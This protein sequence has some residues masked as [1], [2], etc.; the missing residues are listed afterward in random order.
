VRQQNILR[1]LGYHSKFI[2]DFLHDESFLDQVSKIAGERLCPSTFGSHI[3]QV[4]F[5]KVGNDK[6]EV[7]KWH[8]DSV[9][10]VLVIILSDIE[11]MVGGELEVF[12]KNLGGKE[13]TKK[14][15][16]EGLPQEYIEA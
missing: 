4:N 13:A 12:R 2:E 9:D 1:G 5:G 3:V 16:E 14:L 8:F 6:A 7:D 10:Y 11:D 15:A